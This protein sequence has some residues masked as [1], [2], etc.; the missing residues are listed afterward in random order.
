MALATLP[1]MYFFAHVYY[2]DIPSIT[3]ILAMLLLS[4]RKYHKLSTIFAA[5]SVLM[6]QTNIVWVAGTLGVHVVDKMMV[7]V[8]PKMKRENAK[9][10]NFIFAVKAHLQHPKILGELIFGAIR[11]LYGYILIIIGFIAFLF[12]NGSIVVGDKTAHEASIHVPQLFYFSIF[13][14]VF[15][16]SL[17]IPQLLKSHRIFRHPKCLLG[18]LVL[19]GVIAVIVKFNTLVHPYLLADNRHYTFYVWNRFYARHELARFAIIPAYIFGLS[20][21]FGSLDGSIGFKIFFV[22]STV[23]TLCLQRLIEVRYFLIPFLLLRLNRKTVT[24]KWLILE[25]IGNL[26]INQLTFTIFFN[27]KIRWEN[28]DEIQRIIW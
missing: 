11:E 21:I 2:T 4:I 28:F 25:I 5:F 16:C 18:I 8:Y 19:A 13:V 20:T 22:V 10:S 23:L 24:K 12:V 7:K 9:F 6:R 26:L 3:M 27:V 14:L 15:G 17:W 1:P